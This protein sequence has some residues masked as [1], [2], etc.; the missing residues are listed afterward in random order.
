MRLSTLSKLN[1]IIQNANTFKRMLRETVEKKN[2]K[3]LT[4]LI[5]LIEKL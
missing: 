2:W 3:Q 1:F 4:Q 5:G